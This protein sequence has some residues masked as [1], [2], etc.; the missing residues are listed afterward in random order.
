M[1]FLKTKQYFYSFWYLFI[2]GFIRNHTR[3]IASRNENE[4]RYAAH[5]LQSTYCSAR[6][7]QKHLRN[8][9]S[10]M[11]K[12]VGTCQNYEYVYFWG[13]KK[14][15]ARRSLNFRCV[16]S[17]EISR[18]NR[19]RIFQRNETDFLHCNIA[20]WLWE[21]G[22]HSFDGRRRV[23]NPCK[24]SWWNLPRGQK[25]SYRSDGDH[26]ILYDNRL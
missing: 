11:L 1:L 2:S 23:W 13:T 20:V 10:N 15:L 7:R 4:M 8:A 21:E 26:L 3:N 5:R 16:S 14:P 18:L 19:N 17:R 22:A 12:R 9:C 6:D 24:K 25:I